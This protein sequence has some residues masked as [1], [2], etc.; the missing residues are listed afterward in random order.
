MRTL[1][2]AA[3][4]AVSTLATAQVASAAPTA[5][6]TLS[7][8]MSQTIDTKSAY[9]GQPVVLTNISSSDGSG[10]VSGGRL[11]GHVTN[12][13]HAGQGRSAKLQITF[14]RYVSGSGANYAVNGIVTGMQAKTKNNT[15]KEAGGAV[16]GMLVGNA[17]GKS[18]LHTNLGGLAGA[19]G[20]Y[21]VARNS[22]EN[23]SVS[24]GSVVKVRLLS[25]RRQASHY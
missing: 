7:G 5:G 16:I 14:D 24:Q 11:Y 18:V 25:A 22:R 21:I 2:L 4:M 13:V 10:A 17:I 15:L 9:V 23:M 6:T 19:A 1:L 8:T 20:G 12:V 3:V